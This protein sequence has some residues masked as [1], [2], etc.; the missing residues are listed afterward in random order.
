MGIGANPWTP[1]YNNIKVGELL[2]MIQ[3][4]TGYVMY[5]D[6][7]GNYQY[8]P[9]LRSTPAG[10]PKRVFRTRDI[11]DTNLGLVQYAAE[12]VTFSTKDVRNKI[13]LLGIDAYGPGALD[14]I[15]KKFEDSA[16]ISSA[17]GSQPIN[18]VGF[19]QTFFWI[20]SRFV[21]YPFA[22][23]SAQ[24][25]YDML[26][27]PTIEVTFQCTGGQP[28]LYVMDWIVMEHWRSGLTGFPATAADLP[29]FVTGVALSMT[30]TPQGP[31]LTTQVTARYIDPDL[32]ESLTLT[33]TPPE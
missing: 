18:Y 6:A 30:Q 3:Q 8:E 2:A 27:Q 21:S 22:L 16:S 13:G 17:V 10:V 7:M 19:P 28:D 4:T 32:A 29:L 20:D 12:R 24:R 33:T 26:R 5:C 15:L 14:P 25:I 23:A 31:L 9:F 1:I 11:M